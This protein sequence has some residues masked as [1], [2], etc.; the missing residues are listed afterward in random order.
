MKHFEDERKVT[1]KQGNTS[2]LFVIH[3]KILS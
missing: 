2:S 1:A 3:G